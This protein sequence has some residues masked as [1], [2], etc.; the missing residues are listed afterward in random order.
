MQFALVPSNAE[1]SATE[2]IRALG[3]RL[4]ERWRS[5]EGS[6]RLPEEVRELPWPLPVRQVISSRPAGGVQQPV[7]LC[8]DTETGELSWLDAEEDGPAFVVC[9]SAKSGRSNALISAATLMAESGWSVLGLPLSRRSPVA[10]GDFPG[11][12]VAADG[13]D[14]HAGS[15]EP[16]ALFIDDAHKWVGEVDGLR[17]LLEGPGDRAVILAGPTEFF[18]GRNDLLRALPS[19]CGLV[20]AP[21]SGLDASQFGVRR[22]GDEVLRDTRPGR[23]VLVVSGEL[24]GAQVP[25]AV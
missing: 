5:T 13:L 8:V 14:S 11:P 3:Q 19:R 15:T 12:L 10:S 1:A 17:A 6:S 25:L 4:A 16:V 2:V 18:N 21:K 20:L 9:G 24:N 23:G 7:A 22:L